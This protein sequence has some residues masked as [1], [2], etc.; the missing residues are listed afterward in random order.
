MADFQD[1]GAGLQEILRRQNPLVNPEAAPTFSIPA[2]TPGSEAIT[3][4]QS[5]PPAAAEAAP[6]PAPTPPAEAPAA[7][8]APAVQAP[9]GA[10][11]VQPGSFGD[12]LRRVGFALSSVSAG[13]QGRPL[14]VNRFEEDAQR[15][16]SLA[17]QQVQTFGNA[18][19]QGIRYLN[20]VPADQRDEF[21]RSWGQHF[22]ASLPG[23]SR[24]FSTIAGRE[25]GEAI[26]RLAGAN[27]DL[28]APLIRGLSPLQAVEALAR[29][30]VQALV[31]RSADQRNAT[32]IPARIQQNQQVIGAAI[33]GG[34]APPQA[35][36]ML[37]PARDPELMADVIIGRESGGNP[38]ARSPTSSAVGP[39]Q[40]TDGTWLG[41]AQ[42]PGVAARAGVDPELLQRAW[43]GDAQA[44][45]Q[46]L[47]ARTDPQIAR[48]GVLAFVGQNATRLSQ[49]QLAVSPTNLY[50]MGFGEGNAVPLI[51]AAA[52]D[53]Q[54]PVNE[55][56]RADAYQANAAVFRNADG[57]PKTAGQ[58]Y[59]EVNRDIQ[60]RTV[61]A[62]RARGQSAQ[63]GQAAGGMSFGQ[64][65]A[66]NQQQ[67]QG[68]RFTPSEVDTIRRNP[69]Y[70]IDLGIIPQE[71][72]ARRAQQA[73]DRE[74][75]PPHFQQVEEN[76]QRYLAAINPADG[77]RRWAV[78][79]GQ[80]RFNDREFRAALA[81]RA[82]GQPISQ[83]DFG[84]EIVRTIGG[85]SQEQAVETRNAMQGNQI[86]MESDGQG[87]FRLNIGGAQSQPR[88]PEFAQ[89]AT[90]DAAGSQAINLISRMRQQLSS[91]QV[92][93]GLVGVGV[94]ALDS[95]R[96][97]LAQVTQTLSPQQRALLD[98]G[99]Y[100]SMLPSIPGGSA[101][102]NARFQSNLITLA[103]AVARASDPRGQVTERD[104]Q[105]TL[106]RLGTGQFLSSRDQMGAALDE[107]ARSLRETYRGQH[108][109]VM[110]RAQERD[111]RPIPAWAQDPQQQGGGQPAP[112][113]GTAAPA[114]GAAAP[115]ATGAARFQGMT[116]SQ[117]GSVTPGDLSAEDLA[118][119]RAEVDRR[120]GG[121]RR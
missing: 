66:F 50:L 69:N 105:R 94:Q 107:T 87:G 15:A 12:V 35:S 73:S 104:I 56:V 34:Q 21:V 55:V 80:E 3:T 61:Q 28:I 29:P 93:T 37:G 5:A 85:M 16:Q 48:R 7:A 26:A 65:E 67:P 70:Q 79:I 41:T 23:F 78:P 42:Q 77:S 25:D 53:P 6:A 111:R 22:D 40:F 84:P 63:G 62:M 83:Q 102:E 100:T 120:I 33:Q 14:P 58:V 10:N 76:G 71:L 54:R 92:T 45:Q 8:R 103:Y 113:G 82:S 86:S 95:V 106:Q 97:Q 90:A 110:G 4:T 38:N 11:V 52:E 81:L 60:Q 44:R 1:F 75:A 98:V 2:A 108:E 24:L 19:E 64:W 72:Q 46:V 99:R 109:A 91:G 43:S 118:A 27:A 32:T 88:S 18:A 117:L 31:Q 51:R 115:A 36:V 119:W 47:D 49:A 89:L 112:A 116:P 20:R 74:M 39:G 9:P 30:E 68:L 101:T 96:D 59:D 17:L 121:G 13:L 114:G 57:T